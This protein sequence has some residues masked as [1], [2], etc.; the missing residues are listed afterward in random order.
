M[1]LTGEVILD[2]TT[3]EDLKEE[4]RKEVIEEIKENG[5][6]KDEIETFL[7]NTTSE[8]YLTILAN[9]IDSVLERDNDARITYTR[10]RLLAIKSILNI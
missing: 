2:D 8:T 10:K 9:T 6:Y 5:N 7:S 4:V 3:M 1:K